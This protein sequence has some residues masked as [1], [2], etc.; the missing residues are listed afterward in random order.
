MSGSHAICA[1]RSGG[2]GP[3]ARLPSSRLLV[4][5]YGASPV[6]VQ[7]ALRVLTSEGL[8]ESRPG[9]G[10]FVRPSRVARPADYG[11][12]T[13]ALGSPPARTGALAAALRSAPDE[14]IALHSGYPDRDLLPG[15]LVR[16]ALGRATRAGAALSRPPVGGLPD[17]QG[18]FAQSSPPPPLPA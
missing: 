1:R 14:V 5:Q 8:I 17:L 16:S 9:A 12:Q 18:W 10:T 15:R 4:R 6:T 11:W 2:S 3:G 13:A 7:R